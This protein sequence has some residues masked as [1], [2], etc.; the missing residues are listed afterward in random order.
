MR[1][2]LKLEDIPIVR[3][4]PDVFPKDLPG[5]P[6][7]R[8]VEF[9]I[10]LALGTT[11][12]SKAPYRMAPLELKE[13]KIQLQELRF[14]EGFSNIALPS[15]QIDS[16]RGSGGFMV[17]SD[18]LVK[19]LGCVLMK[20][21]KVVAYA[22][23]Q[24]KELNMR[25]RRWFE[26]LKDYDY[27][28]QYH[29]GKANVVADALSRKTIDSLAAIRGCQRQILEDLRSFTSPYQSFGLGSSCGKL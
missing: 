2:D 24:F 13:L 14:I 4:Y 21:G 17:Y 5:L 18:V 6:P 9:T 16:E 1:N 12:I 8:E 3:D 29:L 28:I 10:D 7:D 26:L 15:N 11:S 23:R 25:Q 27:I 19:V 22:S 20:H